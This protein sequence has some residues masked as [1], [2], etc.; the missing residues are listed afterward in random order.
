MECNTPT[1][2]ARYIGQS[3]RPLKKRFS[4]HKDYITSIFPTQ[5]TG[6]HFNLPGLSIDNITITILEKVRKNNESYRKERETS[7]IRRFNT[8][9]K[10]LNRQ[11]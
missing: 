6:Q 8:Y 5:A 10:G 3:F 4:E 9:F 11:P 1:C 7:H 2:K